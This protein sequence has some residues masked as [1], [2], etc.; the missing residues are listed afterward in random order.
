MSE[1]PID[2]FVLE[3]LYD[4]SKN[5]VA[6]TFQHIQDLQVKAFYLLFSQLLFLGFYV[7]VINI[8][9]TLNILPDPILGIITALGLIA[10]VFGML[11]SIDVLRIVIYQEIDIKKTILLAI[12]L[13]EKNAFI[14]PI[15]G[16]WSELQDTNLKITEINTNRIKWAIRSLIL[17]IILGVFE[18]VIALCI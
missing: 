11:H 10:L 13:P 4:I 12:E 16:E 1:T 18:T 15:M 14:K 6:R 8:Q 3:K 7:V 9:F 2:D 17:S 5:A